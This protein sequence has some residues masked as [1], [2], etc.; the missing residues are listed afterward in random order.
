MGFRIEQRDMH[1]RIEFD[2]TGLI[3]KLGNM[4]LKL[5]KDVASKSG[6]C[7]LFFHFRRSRAVCPTNYSSCNVRLYSQCHTRNCCT[8]DDNYK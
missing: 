2:E 6:F 1:L 7:L 5:M 3:I 8:R 4:S